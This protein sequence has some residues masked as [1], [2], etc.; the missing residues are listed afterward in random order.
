M[1]LQKIKQEKKKLRNA[2]IR[3]KISGTEKRP[4]LC[5]SRSAKH[6]MVELVDD[7]KG[8]VLATISDLSTGKK[9]VGK[10]K[11]TVAVRPKDSGEM[12]TKVAV[13]FEIGKLIAK[14]AKDLGIAE[15]VF[16]RRGFKYHGRIKA[17]ADGAREGGLKF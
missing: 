7:V 1:N 4:R 2:R 17:V 13:A 12:T 14:K 9:N 3:A 6:V 15:V 10:R 11:R 8:R 5:V 16:D